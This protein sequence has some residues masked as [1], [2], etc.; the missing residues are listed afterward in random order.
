MAQQEQAIQEWL[1]R[2]WKHGPCPVCSTDNWS[3]GPVLELGMFN[4]VVGVGNIV[5]PA[6]PVSC[7]NCG[8]LLLFNGIVAGVVY[9]PAGRTFHSSTR[10]VRQ[11]A[12]PLDET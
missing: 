5:T 4:P 12:P 9:S 1:A 3:Y 2:K 11:D 7:D 6:F 8:Y 10:V